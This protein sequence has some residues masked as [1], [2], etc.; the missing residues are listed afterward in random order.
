M[1][2]TYSAT[3]QISP[4]E[5]GIVTFTTWEALDQWFEEFGRYCYSVIFH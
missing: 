4:T 5:G 2:T 1:T 3:F